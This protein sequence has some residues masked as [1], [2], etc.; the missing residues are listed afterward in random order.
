MLFW[1]MISTSNDP[2]YLF[3]CAFLYKNSE[4]ARA[5]ELNGFEFRGSGLS[6]W[7]AHANEGIWYVNALYFWKGNEH[8]TTLFRDTYFNPRVSGIGAPKEIN[9]FFALIFRNSKKF[10]NIKN[11]TLYNVLLKQEQFKQLVA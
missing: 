3:A 11:E 9:Y 6:S 8:L 10:I 4:N 7:L 1:G 2:F 5:N